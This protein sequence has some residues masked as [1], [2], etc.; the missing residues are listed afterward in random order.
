MV[1]AS[2]ESGADFFYDLINAPTHT[3]QL[4]SV[5]LIFH[6]GLSLRSAE[7]CHIHCYSQFD[8]LN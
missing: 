8:V 7:I 6:D 3:V 2:S 1:N 5:K 4:F